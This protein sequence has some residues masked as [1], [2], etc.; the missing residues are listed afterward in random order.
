MSINLN[1]INS[2]VENI[3]STLSNESRL[4]IL[5]KLSQKEEKISN[6]AKSLDLNIQDTHRNVNR[7]I[8]SSILKKDS[9]G[10]LQL[11]PLGDILIL[12]FPSFDFVVKNMAYFQDH[13]FNN[14]PEK[15]TQRIGVLNTCNLT[16]GV[17][18][19]LEKW[20]EMIQQSEKYVKVIASQAPLEAV[21]A[22][23]QKADQ[24]SKINLILGKNT[25]FPETYPELLKKYHVSKLELNGFFETKIIEEVD[26]CM[27]ITDK[28][29]SVSLSRSGGDVDID[30]TFFGKNESFLEWCND[31][32]DNIWLKGSV[33]NASLGQKF[34]I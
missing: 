14:L 16:I 17:V 23:L 21:E 32:F 7:M 5:F 18:K 13:T 24:G 25:I 10:F 9:D 19:V 3:I 33:T 26:F 30:Q 15:F 12:L 34:K 20:K 31:L 1:A 2:N 28:E 29:A 22:T 4:L 8:S 6:L 11:T 27:V